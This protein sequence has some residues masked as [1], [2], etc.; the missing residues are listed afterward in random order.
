VYSNHGARRRLSPRLY[1]L[2][3]ACMTLCSACAY[4]SCPGEHNCSSASRVRLKAIDRSVGKKC[5]SEPGVPHTTG[6]SGLGQPGG[7]TPLR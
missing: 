6:Q 7:S 4:A 2:A 5:T 1:D 3:A